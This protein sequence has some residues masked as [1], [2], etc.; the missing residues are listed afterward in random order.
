[1]EKNVSPVITSN[2]NHYYEFLFYVDHTI[3]SLLKNLIDDLMKKLYPNLS[4]SYS[5]LPV[6][7]LCKFEKLNDQIKFR[8]KFDPYFIA[9]LQSNKNLLKLKFSF[10]IDDNSSIG[11]LSKNDNFRKY[12]YIRTFIKHLLQKQFKFISNLNDNFLNFIPSLQ[13][14]ADK[15]F[16]ELK[17]LALINEK[18][19][20][21]LKCCMEEIFNLQVNDWC[22]SFNGGKDCTVLLHTLV[23]IFLA[24]N[25]SRNETKSVNLLWAK[26]CDLFSE[27]NLYM[28]RINRYYGCRLNIYTG[29]DIKTALIDV[30]QKENFRKIFMGCRRTDFPLSIRSKFLIVQKTDNDWP[31]FIRVSPLLD[32]SYNDI[33]SFLLK[34]NVPYCPL[35]DYG[36]TSIDKPDNTIPNPTLEFEIYNSNNN[37]PSINIDS[38]LQDHSNS[39]IYLP[40]FLLKYDEMERCCRTNE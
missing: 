36:Y 29:K 32:W 6:E 17:K 4:I 31:E 2:S 10:S 21:L 25:K 30:H 1:M 22:I 40:A 15:A 27:Q 16:E 35:Y 12:C 9:N 34:L 14:N 11:I 20:Q 7:Y 28:E 38:F 3:L 13:F 18:V 5:L 39:K 26:T 23:T 19:D 37:Y 33:W 8:Y 24:T